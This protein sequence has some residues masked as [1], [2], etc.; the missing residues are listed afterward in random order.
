[1]I[2]PPFYRLHSA[3]SEGE[4]GSSYLWW[5]CGVWLACVKHVVSRE[6]CRGYFVQ[7]ECT[8]IFLGVQNSSG[9]RFDPLPSTQFRVL[10]FA[11]QVLAC[12]LEV[13]PSTA[14]LSLSH[15][16]HHTSYLHIL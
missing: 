9:V 10:H 12:F 11:V 6:S 8:Y 7:V 5:P 1:M 16:R 13:R 4:R 15:H 14:Q 3:A 2:I